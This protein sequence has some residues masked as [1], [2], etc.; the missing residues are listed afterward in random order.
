[1]SAPRWQT[2]DIGEWLMLEAGDNSSQLFA[3]LDGD[4][5]FADAVAFAE[6]QG[7]STDSLADLSISVA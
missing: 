2:E 3:D 6:L 4:G 5:D 7:V 1:M